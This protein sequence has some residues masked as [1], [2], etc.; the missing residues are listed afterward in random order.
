MVVAL[1]LMIGLDT[2]LLIPK[3]LTRPATMA[4]SNSIKV[5]PRSFMAPSRKTDPRR[6][7]QY[8]LQ[9]LGIGLAHRRRDR[10]RDALEN[11]GIRTVNGS[12]KVMGSIR[13]RHTVNRSRPRKGLR[14]VL[15]GSEIGLVIAGGPWAGAAGEGD[16]CK[17]QGEQFLQLVLRQIDRHP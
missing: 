3:R 6:T 17:L 8:G 16:H 14:V 12:S 10:D 11:R 13:F 2:K 7:D 1:P 4:M 9:D 5:V 15:S